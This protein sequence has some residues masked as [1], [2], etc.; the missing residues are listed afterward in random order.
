MLMVVIIGPS[1]KMLFVRFGVLPVSVDNFKQFEQ[2][3]IN[4]ATWN[5]TLKQAETGNDL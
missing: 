4:S 1:F 5:Q 3:K 2:Q